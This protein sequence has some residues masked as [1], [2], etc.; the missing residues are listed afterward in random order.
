MLAEVYMVYKELCMISTT[1]L[2][3]VNINLAPRVNTEE[4]YTTSE[5][6]REQSFG[7]SPGAQ[8]P[9]VV[10]VD[11]AT[12]SP[13]FE[14]V[15]EATGA[16]NQVWSWMTGLLRGQGSIYFQERGDSSPRSFP[17]GTL[18]PLGPQCRAQTP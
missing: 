16:T 7:V 12:K 8:V 18:Q 11:L 17:V 1:P 10:H 15:W 5:L 3:S 14:Q 13:E 6:S 4:K 2:G 9:Q